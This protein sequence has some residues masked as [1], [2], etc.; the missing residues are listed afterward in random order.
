MRIAVIVFSVVF[1]ILIL[2][3]GGAEFLCARGQALN[4]TGLIRQ[5]QRL[6]PLV[7]EYFYEEYRLS[8]R[9]DALKAAIR[10]EPIKPAYHMYYGLVILKQV[11]RTRAGDRQALVEICKAAEL[12]PYS[13]EYARICGQYKAVI[14][15]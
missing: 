10:R 7:S 8:G 3:A 6:N 9:I 12:K 5:A 2:M 15:P 4:D 1:M 14:L 13:K 11:P